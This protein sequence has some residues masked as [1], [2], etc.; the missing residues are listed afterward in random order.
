MSV[1]SKLSGASWKSLT[2][3]GSSR[4]SRSRASKLQKSSHTISNPKIYS[5]IN[6]AITSTSFTTPEL[7][8]TEDGSTLEENEPQAEILI[9]ALYS[10]S[11]S[12]FTI[13]IINVINLPV[14]MEA[15]SVYVRGIIRPKHKE[16]QLTQPAQGCNPQF[17]ESFN[18]DKIIPEDFQSNHL[19]L[20]VHKT[21]NNKSVQELFLALGSLK[22][23][24]GVTAHF[25]FPLTPAT[26]SKRVSSVKET[27][28]PHIL[29]I[30]FC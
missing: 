26:R 23:E 12:S 30:S 13:T 28:H 18:F 4:S 19:T 7:K 24:N 5:S 10:A 11:V 27:R 25:K 9:S 17:N 2:S 8:P 29:I 3:I 15:R 1:S 6:E 14:R 16:F 21:S 20:S 22:M